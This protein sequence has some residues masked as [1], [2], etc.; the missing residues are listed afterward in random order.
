[1]TV[2]AFRLS[3]IVFLLASAMACAA[4]VK[5]PAVAG[6]FYPADPRQ[7]AAEVSTLLEGGLSEAPEGDLIALVSPHAGYRYSG[8]VAAFSYRQLMGKD[9]RT[10]VLIG[11][12]HHYPLTGV[13]VYVGGGMKTPLGTVRIDQK[14]ARGLINDA[15]Q[16]SSIPE[17]FAREHSLEVQLP[18]L[19]Q[20][21][22]DF[23]IVPILV[24]APTRESF[25]HLT[26]RLSDLL[27]KDKRAVIVVST[28]LSHYHDYES[29]VTRDRK[30]IDAVQRLSTGD[31]ERL[32]GSGEGELCGGYPVIYALAAARE[33][34][35]TNAVLYSYA[36]SGDVTGDK[37][38]VVGYAA[39]GIYRSSLTAEEKQQLLS[40]ARKTITEYI[41][42]GKVPD[43]PVP[44]PRLAAN[45][46]A[47]V[48]INRQGTLRGCIGTMQPVMPL[49][50]SVVANAVAASS[51]DPRFPPMKRS[52]LTDMEVEV[53]VLSPFE[54]L[55][56]ASRVQIGRHGLYLV[57]GKN[58]AVFLPQVPVEQGWDRT[59]YL[60]HLARKAGL[61][62]NG[63]KDATL[64]TFTADVLREGVP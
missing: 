10:V 12:S 63:W 4:K 24:G 59:A 22:K 27:R 7:L 34:G 33:L 16:V 6:S 3:A 30:V 46:A 61:E 32:L 31:L 49:Y 17:A 42:T 26:R 28:D 23:R 14:M 8:Q 1:M 36:N 21:L 38:R 55:D 11:P 64:Y 45:A 47:F 15:A 40:L 52:E 25:D 51:R 60:E 44:G 2:R 54:K 20:V 19:Q 39:M 43:P 62:N 13:A 9:I 57:K 58:T 5:E 56:D 37:T 18:F 48:T 41:S 53:S 35:A 29:A 50:K